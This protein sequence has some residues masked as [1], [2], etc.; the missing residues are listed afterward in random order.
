MKLKQQPPLSLTPTD[1]LPVYLPSFRCLPPARLA[2][3]APTSLC[4]RLSL[5]AFTFP[6]AI[7]ALRAPAVPFVSARVVVISPAA[8]SQEPRSFLWGGQS[9]ENE[10]PLEERANPCALCSSIGTHGNIGHMGVGVCSG[11]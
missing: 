1:K 9:V 3:G 5:S 7:L 11:G 10:A 2:L 4:A 6:C 8:L